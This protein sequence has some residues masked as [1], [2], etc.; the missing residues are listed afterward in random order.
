MELSE[1]RFSIWQF[2]RLMVYLEDQNANAEGANTD[3][4]TLFN[5][6][7]EVWGRLDRDLTRL[8]ES[9]MDAYAEM[10]MDQEVVIEDATAPL[11]I[12]A[13]AAFTAVIQDMDK[14]IDAGGD[15]HLMDSLTFERRELDHLI[16]R[17]GS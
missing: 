1:V 15:K 16:K 2:V 5:A 13:K 6:W 7:S 14:A 17:L 11:I 8:A 12:T 4:L 10:M 9:D 3:Q